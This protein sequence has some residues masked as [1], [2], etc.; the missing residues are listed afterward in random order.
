MAQINVEVLNKEQ[1]QMLLD[2]WSK[3]YEEKYNL[4]V[5]LLEEVQQLREKIKMITD[6]LGELTDGN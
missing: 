6:D 5:K 1:K 4:Q 2:I 3:E